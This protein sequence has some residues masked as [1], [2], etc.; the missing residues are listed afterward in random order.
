MHL[1]LNEHIFLNS[2][3]LIIKNFDDSGKPV[4]DPQALM[5]HEVEDE[6]LC[7]IAEHKCRCVAIPLSVI[8]FVLLIKKNAKSL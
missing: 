2:F 4:A 3:R 7:L 6:R 1:V 5:I 8:P